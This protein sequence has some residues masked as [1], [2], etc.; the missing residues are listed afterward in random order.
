M[1]TV[2]GRLTAD[3][4][5][6]TLEDGRQVVNF[7]IAENYRFRV[8]GSDKAKQVTNFYDCAYWIKTG[9][10]AHLKK[11]MVVE[12]VGR[13]GVKAWKGTDG[14]PKAHLTLHVQYI[15]LHGNPKKA[16]A[17]TEVPTQESDKENLPF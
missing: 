4:K 1:Q 5:M 15:Q 10:A 7:T 14:E 9:I 11:G 2:I 13:I 8:K 12:T 6:T 16:T 3:A 17:S